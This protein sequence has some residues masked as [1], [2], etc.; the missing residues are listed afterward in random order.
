MLLASSFMGLCVVQSPFW[1]QGFV[2]CD[3]IHQSRLC[4]GDPPVK[5]APRKVLMY[6]SQCS[7][8]LGIL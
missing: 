5:V 6:L 7:M 4:H 1:T 2:D 8:Q 3:L